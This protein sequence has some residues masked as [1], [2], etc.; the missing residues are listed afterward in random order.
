[1]GSRLDRFRGLDSGLDLKPVLRAREHPPPHPR[2]EA[3]VLAELLNCLPQALGECAGGTS[4]PRKEPAVPWRPVGTFRDRWGV[5]L[6]V[7]SLC[8]GLIGVFSEI[9]TRRQLCCWS[10]R[11]PGVLES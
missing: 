1:M 8:L 6:A 5:G 4:A 3:A 9:R 7:G 2:G 11:L 10:F